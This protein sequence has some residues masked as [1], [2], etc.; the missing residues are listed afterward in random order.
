MIVVESFGYLHGDPPAAEITVDVRLRLLVGFGPESLTGQDPAVRM[1]VL[2]A[3][4]AL[5]LLDALAEVAR[6]LVSPASL[7]APLTI[8]I[9]CSGGRRRSVALAHTFAAL[10][11][12][13]WGYRVET[14]HRDIDKDVAER[15]Q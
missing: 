15:V 13:R 3:P 14:H 4:G 9:G 7:E 11:R 10:L 8:A 6:T 2:S 12:E 1:L 5:E